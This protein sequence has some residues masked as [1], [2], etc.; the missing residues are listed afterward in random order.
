[1]PKINS[2]QVAWTE[3]FSPKKKFGV[4]R[5]NLSLETGGKK[6]T[7]TYGGGHPFDV[8]LIRLPPKT[9]NWPLHEHS[10]QWEAYI[11]ISG[12]GILRTPERSEE[13][14]GGDYIVLP[15]GEAH[16]I[17][18]EGNEDLI[19]YVIADNP[20]A[21]VIYYPDSRKYFIKPQRKVFDTEAN[22]FK[23]EE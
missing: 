3:Q 12:T 14:R 4:I 19:Y 8:E 7:G 2:D 1:M 22:Y 17:L 9:T 13:I 20:Q 18:N 11:I 6:D 23:G 21:D 15:P 10:A 16:Q 5:K